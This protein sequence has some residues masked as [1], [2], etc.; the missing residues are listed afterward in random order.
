MRLTKFLGNSLIKGSKPNAHEAFEKF[1]VHCLGLSL[2]HFPLHGSEFMKFPGS[3]AWQFPEL[4]SRFKNQ[5]L[6]K[7]EVASW[8]QR[9]SN[10]N[11]EKYLAQMAFVIFC[12]GHASTADDFEKWLN[13]SVSVCG[14]SEGKLSLS[15]PFNYKISY[16]SH[17]LFEWSFDKVSGIHGIRFTCQWCFIVQV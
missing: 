1:K 15:I 2:H 3:L 14:Q 6:P 11:Q 5:N 13:D 9:F 16:L 10:E 12:E 17:S 4:F 7:G 8:L